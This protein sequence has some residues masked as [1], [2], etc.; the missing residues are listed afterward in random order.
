MLDPI[1]IRMMDFYGNQVLTTIP[2]DLAM[3]LSNPSCKLQGSATRPF[4]EGVSTFSNL[5]ISCLPGNYP[6]QKP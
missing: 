3:T 6:I 2:G 1:R 4:F 5:T